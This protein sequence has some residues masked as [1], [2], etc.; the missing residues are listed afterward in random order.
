MGGSYWLMLICCFGI[1]HR[2]VKEIGAREDK[3]ADGGFRLEGKHQTNSQKEYNIIGRR[4]ET[5]AAVNRW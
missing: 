3:T 2:G 1:D 4:G 5:T